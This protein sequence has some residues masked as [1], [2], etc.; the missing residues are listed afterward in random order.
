MVKI[1]EY[2]ERITVPRAVGG[3]VNPQAVQNAGAIARATAD[4]ARIGTELALHHKKA[5]DATLFNQMVIQSQREDIEWL[6]K[7]RQ[8]N[9]DDPFGS[10]IKAE[11]EFKRRYFERQ[12]TLPR[13]L[14]KQWRLHTDEQN[15]RTFQDNLSW[16][17]R[18]STEIY[19]ARIEQSIEDN[20][21]LMLR[22]G[23]EGQDPE[24]LLK[25]VDA[26]TVA[27]SAFIASDKLEG[28]NRTGRKS[29]MAFYMDGVIERNPYEAKRVLDAKKYDDALGADGVSRAYK[30]AEAGI[31]RRDAEHRAQ[32]RA[33]ANED[34]SAIIEASGF[35]IPVDE[36][37]AKDVR[38]RLASIGDT[39]TA[40]KVSEALILSEMVRQYEGLPLPD[41]GRA[42]QSLG[43]EIQQ[44][45]TR[46]NINQYQALG[47]VYTNRQK[48]IQ[49]DGIGAF[50][51]EFNIQ[52]VDPTNP[53]AIAQ[54]IPQRQQA[55]RAIEDLH[56][57]AVPLYTGS[58]V[59]AMQ[60]HYDSLPSTQKA[61]YAQAVVGSM[62]DRDAYSLGG[63][64]AK[65][66]MFTASIFGLSVDDPSLARE[67]ARG[68][69]RPN[70]FKETEI[71]S[72]V[73]K[74]VDGLIDDPE[75]MNVVQQLVRNIA[76]ERTAQGQKADLKDITHEVIGKPVRLD[77]TLLG[78]G[79]Y[80][81]LPFRDPETKSFVSGGEFRDTVNALN[82][83][84]LKS[85][86]KDVPYFR[87]KPISDDDLRTFLSEYRLKAVGSG[88]YELHSP[89]GEFFVPDKNGF[90]YKF[91][92]QKI[93]TDKPSGMFTRLF[94]SV[95]DAAAIRRLPEE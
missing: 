14:Q 40:Q 58:E 79:G 94:E 2:E 63:M 49:S 42:I 95:S 87:N 10:A 4:V 22:A 33:E 36:G 45:P 51:G 43:E 84:T 71:V 88:V 93:A 30:A 73:R 15:I 28:V 19:A 1:V 11:V 57:V 46:E 69:E 78:F 59:K 21:L 6:D 3:L 89:D 20:N 27:A 66:D 35:G 56:G 52:P 81:V 18:R 44:K 53:V 5:N 7:M 31:K 90:P 83:E 23:R 16:E 47:R 48:A 37:H 17:N 72:V 80:K 92:L 55:Q 54:S 60:A 67:A 38:D 70:T 64:I 26:A 25:N 39:Q 50:A 74:S 61:E 12:Q 8:E 32:V 82:M 24:A 13:D 68:E 75:T 77:G 91:N 62:G 34:A 86:H 85:T 29:G 9:A 76:E 65:N 41:M